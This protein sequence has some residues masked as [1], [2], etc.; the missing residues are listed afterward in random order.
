[1]KAIIIDDEKH[2]R[3]GLMLLAE[4]ETYGINKVFEAKDGAEAKTIIAEHEPEIIFTDMNMPNIDGIDLLKWLHTNQTGS[5]VIVV[6]GYEDFQYMRNAIYYGGFD[7]ILK[8][9]DPDVLN[10][11]LGRA[12]EE[13]REQDVKRQVNIEN[14]QVM[15]TVRPLYWDHLFSGIIK[16]STVPPDTI[17]KIKKEIAITITDL[18]CTSAIIRVDDT[19]K[20]I[21]NGDEDLAFFTLLNICNEIIK[22]YGVAFKHVDK[23]DEIVLLIWDAKRIQGFIQKIHQS[24]YSV[25]NKYCTFAYGREKVT[26]NAAYEVALKTLNNYNLLKHKNNQQV[27]TYQE[28][29]DRPIF[30]LLDVSEELKWTLQS[31]NSEKLDVTLNKIFQS[32]ETTYNLSL[33]QL[34]TW[35]KQFEIL[36]NNWMKEYEIDPEQLQPIEKNYWKADGS[37]SFT[38]FKKHKRQEFLEI[39]ELLKN[40]QY[41]K[42]KSCIQEIEEYLC[43]RYDQDIKLQDIAD[44]FFLSREYIA[45]KFKQE[46]NQ[47][48]IHYLT[49]IRLEKAKDL[50]ENQH[51]KV[52]DIAL[53]VGYQNE[54]YFCKVFKKSLGLT[55]NEYRQ[56]KRGVIQ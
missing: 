5:K 21:Y 37:F 46:T 2:V 52:C 31:G 22:S 41:Q 17:E 27:I 23:Q 26:P 16:K 12:V 53:K 54:K 10:E 47:T 39:I 1:M 40:V 9:I 55:P 33:E 30:H 25:T 18:P 11:T 44:R 6:S 4:W 38:L 19:I 49:Q 43:Q 3:E 45:R 15:N 20:S 29:D 14:H 7:Y 13:W 35:E 36:R 42:G 8:P 32:M 56:G 28:I 24:I 34:Q 50:L 51:L 48:I